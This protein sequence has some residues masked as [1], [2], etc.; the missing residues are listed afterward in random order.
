[1]GTSASIMTFNEPQN[2]V[3]LC[4]YPPS[5]LHHSLRH[6]GC[7]TAFY[8]YSIFLLYTSFYIFCIM[9]YFLFSYFLFTTDFL[10]FIELKENAFILLLF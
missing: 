10:I 5:S 1:M 3:N 7:V 6:V 4:L 8:L 9:I 2:V